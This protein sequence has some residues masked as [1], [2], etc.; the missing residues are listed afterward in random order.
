MTLTTEQAQ[1]ALIAF[2]RFGLGARPGG[3]AAIGANP[4]G[5]LIAELNRANIAE[6]SDP[7]LP[8]YAQ[9]CKASQLGFDQAEE[10]RSQEMSARVAKQMSVEIGFVERLVMFWSNHFS[11]TVNKIETVR[12][13][14]GQW[15]RDVIRKNVLGK[16][17]HML[18]GTMNHPAMIAYLDNDNSIG[19]RSRRGVEWGVGLNENLARE[20]MEL[21]TIGSG[22][23]YTEAD[24]TAMAKIL[25]GWSYVRGWEADE[26]FEGGTP[27]NRGQFIYRPL[28]HEP[29][30]IT[31][32]GKRYAPTGK[33]QCEAVLLDLARSPETAEHI[34]FKLVHHFITDEPT[35]AMVNPIKQVFID[36]D[37]DLKAVALALINLP[38]AWSL[39]FEKI[40]TPYE[41]T[42]AQYRALGASYRPNDSWVFSEPLYALRHMAWEAPSPKGYSD[43]TLTWLNPDAMRV[44]LDLAQFHSWEFKR[45]YPGNVVVLARKLFDRAL[46]AQ[47]WDRIA[48][49]AA[50]DEWDSNNNAL[51][52]LLSCP[53]FQ[54]R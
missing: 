16:F 31:L 8:T 20:L 53:E 23:G 14:F 45:D 26:R 30:V 52:V 25:T 37:G 47:T 46:S 6:I 2:N 42:I 15:E 36:T 32:M 10:I 34:A 40:R 35:P 43:D 19:P 11:M 28:W 24:V 7:R 13:T 18:R 39:P 29:G 49:A 1:K 54:R 3:P 21:H 4:K 38:E 41:M 51:T 48:A 5:R 50:P 12:G 17:R 22:G 27:Q 33:D 44:R 9:A